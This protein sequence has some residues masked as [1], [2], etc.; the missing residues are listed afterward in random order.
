[1]EKFDIDYWLNELIH[2]TVKA[3]L[4]HK[5]SDENFNLDRVKQRIISEFER[6]ENRLKTEPFFD[7]DMTGILPNIQTKT[8]STVINSK[9]VIWKN[10]N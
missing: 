7:E 8:I 9:Q 2:K 3:Y 6:L 4:T 1:M 10:K 5:D